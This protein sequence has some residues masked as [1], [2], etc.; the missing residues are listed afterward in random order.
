MI[1]GN[2]RLKVHRAQLDLIAL[3]QKHARLRSPQPALCSLTV[4]DSAVMKQQGLFVH[5]KTISY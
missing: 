1:Q 3:S 4:A 5:G 2:R